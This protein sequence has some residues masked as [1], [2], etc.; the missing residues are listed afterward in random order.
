MNKLVGL[1]VAFSLIGQPTVYAET[2]H[3]TIDRTAAY[4]K[5][6]FG[7]MMG[8]KRFFQCIFAPEKS[9]CSPAERKQARKWLLVTST[10]VVIAVGAAVGF[11]V[12]KQKVNTYKQN[13]LLKEE[14]QKLSSSLVFLIDNNLKQLNSSNFALNVAHIA[15]N[16]DQLDTRYINVIRFGDLLDFALNNP[17]SQ[18]NKIKLIN[19]ITRLQNKGYQFDKAKFDQLKAR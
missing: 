14:A 19:L 18:D 15:A 3:Q 9:N 11:A 8:P 5:K 10:V 17:L 1:L 2:V 4:V 13:E 12:T 6:K 16:L 7:S